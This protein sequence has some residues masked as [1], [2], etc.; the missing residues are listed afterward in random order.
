MLCGTHIV[1]SKDA[2]ECFTVYNVVLH[3]RPHY[4]TTFSI[5]DTCSIRTG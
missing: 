5:V 3:I 4:I 2:T 1:M